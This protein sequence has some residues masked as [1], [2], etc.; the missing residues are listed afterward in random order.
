M[1]STRESCHLNSPQQ[2]FDLWSKNVHLEEVNKK[3]TD[4]ITDLETELEDE[5][6]K[7]DELREQNKNFKSRSQQ[8]IGKV[9]HQ[10]EQEKAKLEQE[11]ARL[12]DK[13]RYLEGKLNKLELEEDH[14]EQHSPGKILSTTLVAAF[15]GENPA[16]NLIKSKVSDC[17]TT[18]SMVYSCNID[19]TK[20]YIELKNQNGMK[21][22]HEWVIK[23][24]PLE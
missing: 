10:L 7:V 2:L 11:N 23:R 8:K 14:E 15:Q 12:K 3:L 19:A 22:G 9:T 21:L 24:Q 13:N 20:A 16:K 18:S 4:K 5:K 17:I 1:A 6:K